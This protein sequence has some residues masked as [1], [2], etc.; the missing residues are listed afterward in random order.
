MIALSDSLTTLVREVRA[1]KPTVWFD[2]EMDQLVYLHE[3]CSFRTD[4]VDPF[5]TLLWHP[6]TE[7]IVG[8]KLKGIRSVY[9]EIVEARGFT[10]QE[11]MPLLDVIAGVMLGSAFSDALRLM[12]AE[13]KAEW[14]RKYAEAR[15]IADGM[16]V[17]TD[18][19]KIALA[20]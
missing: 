11:F 1:F 20:A 13:R 17:P 6:Q 7:D 12:G 16:S 5:L 8:I 10:G 15:Q 3:D 9:E 19:S 4:R 18:L 14:R 2:R